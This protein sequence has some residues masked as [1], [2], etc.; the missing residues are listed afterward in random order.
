DH[1]INY[2]NYFCNQDNHQVLIDYYCLAEKYK[3]NKVINHINQLI[4]SKNHVYHFSKIAKKCIEKKVNN[5]TQ[6]YKILCQ[7][8][9]S[10]PPDLCYETILDGEL[11]PLTDE[12]LGYD[13]DTVCCRHAKR[14]PVL[15]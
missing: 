4:E 8:I 3:L 5:T 14:Q 12:N 2:K 10:F 6:L 7:K 11:N 13:S 1:M 9:S 15:L